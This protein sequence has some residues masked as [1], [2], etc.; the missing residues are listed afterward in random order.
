MDPLSELLK[1]NVGAQPCLAH[2]HPVAAVLTCMDARIDPLRVFG[3]GP[4]EIYCVRTAG[5]V[6][7]PEVAGSLEIGLAVGCPL[8]LVMGHT[9]CAAVKLAR[10]GAREH[11]SVTRHISWAARGLSRDA[12]ID[13]AAEANVRFAVTE[14]RSRLKGRVEGAMLDL[15]TGKVRALAC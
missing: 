5:H 4:G 11:Y 8:V 3:R 14:L 9:D 10:G 6:A 15:A 2:G 1:G 13:E 7:G 12:S